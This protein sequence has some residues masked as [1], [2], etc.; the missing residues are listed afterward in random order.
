MTVPTISYQPGEAFARTMDEQDP[1]ARFR[2]EFL[3]PKSPAGPGKGEAI[4]LCGNSLGLQP[5]K[6]REYINAELDDWRD[7]GVEGHVHARHP[8]LPYHEFL[9]PATARLVGALPHEVVTMNSLTTNLHLLMVSFYRPTRERHRILIEAGAFPSDQYAVA[10]QA[11]F[12]GYDPKEAI[13]ELKPRPGEAILRPEDILATIEREGKSL[14]LIL[15]GNVNYLTGQAFDMKA[16][17]E[18]GHR[19]GAKVGFDLAHGAGNIQAKLHD[20]NADF[21]A[22]CSYK[23]LNA[24]PGAIAGCF[25]HERHARDASLQKFAG[26][27]GHDKSTRFKMGPVFEAIPSAESWQLSNPPIF[28]LAALRA[29][30]DL[31]DEAGMDRLREKSVRLTGYLAY[32]TS[33]IPSAEFTVITPADPEQRGC[34]LSLKVRSN[35]QALLKKFSEADVIADFREPDVIR[36]APTPLYNSFRDVFRFGEILSRF[37]QPGGGPPVEAG[38]NGH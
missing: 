2:Q 33:R 28:Q 18:A 7:L 1:L 31:F 10:S 35:A 24:G 26:W 17:T 23:Y 29:S 11:R 16:I 15:I 25:V 34:H 38:N 36:V 14:A 20:S 22:W 4:Y 37:A 27:W 30:M 8:W 12:H 3:F 21:A 13:V 9:I 19:Q 6:A 32:L 5:K